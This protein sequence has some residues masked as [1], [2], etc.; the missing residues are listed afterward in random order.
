MRSYARPASSRSRRPRPRFI[1]SLPTLD[2]SLLAPALVPSRAQRYPLD[3]LLHA[4]AGTSL[5]YLAR[6][7]VH[8]AVRH[9]LDGR[10]GTFLMPSYHHGVEVEAVRAAGA[11]VRFYRVDSAMQI[12]LEDLERRL[13]APDVRGVYLTHFVGFPQPIHEVMALARRRSLPVIEDCALA[14]LSSDENGT[15]LGSNGDASIFCLYKS[16]PVPHGGLLVARAIP[17]PELASPPVASTL[18][19]LGGLM[20]THFALRQ[21]DFGRS[22][23]Q[24][25][26]RAGHLAWDSIAETV[27]TGTTHLSPRDLALGGS[28]LLPYLIGHLDLEMVVVR[29]R[30]NFRRL[31]EALDGVVPII[32]APL[33]EGTCPLFL[34]VRIRGREKAVVQAALSARGVDAVDFWNSSDPACPGREFPEVMTLRREVLELPC[35]QS[36]DDEDIDY[37][38]RAVKD[39]LGHA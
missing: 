20:L 17:I 4:S 39:V 14:L 31:A 1:S 9:F 15:P 7:A 29:R 30:R 13:A 26:Q 5:Y 22:L 34:P 10:P 11:G 32:G 3:R 37:V 24:A 23:R 6:G 8:Q 21:G 2:L 19:H 35:H 27:K 28:R 16:L 18:H 12:D 38:A 36:L 33:P 25:V